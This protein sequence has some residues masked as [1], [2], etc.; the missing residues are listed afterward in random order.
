M[1]QIGSV[2]FHDS[3][4]VRFVVIVPVSRLLSSF[5]KRFNFRMW[6]R[7][8]SFHIYFVADCNLQMET[9]FCRKKNNNRKRNGRRK[10]CH[11]NCEINEKPI[12]METG[13][14]CV[15]HSKNSALMFWLSEINIYIFMYK[16][17]I[18]LNI[19][20]NWTI[21]KQTKQYFFLLLQQ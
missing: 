19:H 14:F 3:V 2:S 20:L 10:K 21:I 4:G 18:F 11:A 8:N 5:R 9:Q 13:I 16:T 1:F 7:K 12:V 15:Y 17:E 6:A